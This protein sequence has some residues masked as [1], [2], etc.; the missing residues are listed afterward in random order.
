MIHL[1]KNYKNLN[2]YIEEFPYIKIKDDEDV[3]AEVP[4]CMIEF[5]RIIEKP[6]LYMNQ[7]LKIPIALSEDEV[8]E[9]IKGTKLFHLK[10]NED[11]TVE[12]VKK[13]DSHFSYRLPIDT[14]I[15]KLMVLNG[16][17][18]IVDNIKKGDEINGEN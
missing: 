16:E 8:R 13:E 2:E 5:G 17:L 9:K 14:P 12:E 18:G 1:I 6:V 4:L 10:L 11:K 15:E 7:T 3:Y